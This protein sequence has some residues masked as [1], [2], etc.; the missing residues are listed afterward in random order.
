MGLVGVTVPLGPEGGIHPQGGGLGDDSV[1][2]TL[3][4]GARKRLQGDQEAG[5]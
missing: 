1:C 4:S 2:D 3:P 5:K